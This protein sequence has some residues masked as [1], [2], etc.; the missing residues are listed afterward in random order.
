[1]RQPDTVLRRVGCGAEADENATGW[2]MFRADL[3]GEDD[4]PEL[5]AYCPECA[6]RVFD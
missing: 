6:G 5:A 3:P 2:R 4:E 1:M